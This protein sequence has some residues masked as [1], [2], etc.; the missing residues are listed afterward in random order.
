MLGLLSASH[1]AVWLMGFVVLGVG[2]FEQDIVLLEKL[3]IVVGVRWVIQWILFFIINRKLDRTVEWFSFLLMDFAFFI[4][5][6]FFGF[7]VMTRR[8]PRTSWN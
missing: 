7:F 8:K 5:Y 4:Y 2:L 3:G 6:V 1:V